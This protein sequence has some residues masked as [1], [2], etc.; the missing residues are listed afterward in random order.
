MSGFVRGGGCYAPLVDA[1]EHICECWRDGDKVSA[2]FRGAVRERIVRCR[3]CEH[4]EEHYG[5]WMGDATVCWAWED[6]MEQPAWT[7]PDGFCHKGTPR[8]D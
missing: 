6:G 4:F 8:E 1:G 3:D 2:K 7:D 5:G